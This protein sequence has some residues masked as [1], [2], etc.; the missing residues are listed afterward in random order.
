MDDKRFEGIPK[1]YQKFIL[2][3][4]NDP[5]EHGWKREDVEYISK[6]LT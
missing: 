5:E 3:N 4:S 2:S 1:N 6:C